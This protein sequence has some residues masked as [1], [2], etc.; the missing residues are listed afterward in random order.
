MCFYYCTHFCIGLSTL[1]L[2]VN[3]P[4]E[5]P[6]NH[7]QNTLDHLSKTNKIEIIGYFD[8]EPRYES[9]MLAYTSHVSV[10]HLQSR[11]MF[12][13]SGSSATSKSKA[14]ELA[15][16][17]AW[18]QFQ[19]IECGMVAGSSLGRGL[20]TSTKTMFTFVGLHL[21]EGGGSSKRIL[22]LQ[23][24]CQSN[25]CTV[26]R[27]S[28]DCSHH[29][30]TRSTGGAGSAA[31]SGSPTSGA[32]ASATKS[33][34][35]KRCKSKLEEHF[36]DRKDNISIKYVSKESPRGGFTSKVY[37][38]DIGYADGEGPSKSAAENDAA[39]NA[40]QKLEGTT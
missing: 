26:K 18:T 6:V 36:K 23:N 13:G 19:T 3:Q 15:A 37:C 31:G 30:G 34:S 25:Y 39:Y 2:Q 17:D 22:P 5:D 32:S 33:T 35:K 12:T 38:P 8:Q 1:G 14:R 7:Y 28:H 24:V 4:R 11:D 9:N 16:K 20:L 27:C 10:R 29:Y 40:L 21:G